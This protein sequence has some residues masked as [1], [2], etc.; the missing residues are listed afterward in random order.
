MP[1]FVDDVPMEELAVWFAALSVGAVLIGIFVVKPLLR[2]LLGPGPDCNASIN[3]ATSG[4]ACSTAC[5][6]AC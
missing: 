4:Y 1:E 5:S 6:G 2:L 3:Y